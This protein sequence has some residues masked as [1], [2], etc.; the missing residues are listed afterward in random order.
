MV[1]IDEFRETKNALLRYYTSNLT[2]QGARLIGVAVTLF[3]LIQLVQNSKEV[4]LSTILL[5]DFV[6]AI[7]LS[8]TGLLILAALKLLLFGGILLALLFFVIRSIFRFVVFGYLSSY[9]I[10]LEH[11]EVSESTTSLHRTIHS[12]VVDNL[13]DAKQKVFWIFPLVWF[14]SRGKPSQHRK[15][16]LICGFFGICTT[17]ILLWFLW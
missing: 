9:L 10:R 6:P 4:S 14:V 13:E 3:T 5:S 8:E 7:Q 15:G 11:T 12:T 1:D 2:S 16:L 17:L